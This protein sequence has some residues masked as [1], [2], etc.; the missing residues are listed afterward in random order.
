MQRMID[1][2][3]ASLAEG[4]D[5]HRY[6]AKWIAFAEMRYGQH[7]LSPCPLCLITILFNAT[8]GAGS[9]FVKSAFS[10]TLAAPAGSVVA[11]VLGKFLPVRRIK[12]VINWHG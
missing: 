1:S 4:L 10:F 5:V 6:R 11:D 3:V 2:Q 9:R 7:N 12:T 8:P